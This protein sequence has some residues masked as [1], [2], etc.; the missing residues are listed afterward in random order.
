MISFVLLLMT[1]GRTALGATALGILVIMVRKL[2]R[3][4]AI[5]L[6]IAIICGPLIFRVVVSLPGFE[7]VKTKLSSLQSSVRGELFA[8]AW[9]EAKAKPIIG[10]G[11]GMASVMAQTAMGREYHNSWLQYAV[12]HGIPFA[13]FIMCVFSWLPF[14]GL[15][16]MKKCQT[17]EMKDMANLSSA[18]LAGYVF[19]NFFGGG[20]YS[21][22]GILLFYPVVALQEGIRA[23]Q[24]RMES[25]LKEEYF[26]G[27]NLETWDSVEC[28]EKRV[29]YE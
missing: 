26:E 18:F 15:L 5:F 20:L 8:L 14:R 22:T 7:A 27:Y 3:N 9:N 6:A 17:D 23:E 25:Y 21:T 10:W 28:P 11:T 13:F 12:D 24:Q 2:K 19:A 29:L 16:L 1:A 4:I